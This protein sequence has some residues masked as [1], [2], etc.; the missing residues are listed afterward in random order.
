MANQVFI[1]NRSKK[2]HNLM[3]KQVKF[4]NIKKSKCLTNLVNQHHLNSLYLSF[5]K[6]LKNQNMNP[7]FMNQLQIHNQDQKLKP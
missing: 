5:N 1:N 2:L 4:Q 7:K 3:N 6:I